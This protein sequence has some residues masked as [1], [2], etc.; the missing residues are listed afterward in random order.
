[1]MHFPQFWRLFT[2][3]SVENR[4]EWK[5]VYLLYQIVTLRETSQKNIG[6]FTL[7]GSRA[8]WIAVVTEKERVWAHERHRHEVAAKPAL[9]PPLKL[10]TAACSARN[11]VRNFPLESTVTA[12]D[13]KLTRLNPCIS[14]QFISIFLYPNFCKCT[15]FFQN[16]WIYIFISLSGR[17]RYYFDK[18]LAF[19]SI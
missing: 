1:M 9:T 4:N 10:W 17:N 11:S 3:R 5:T 14:V 15:I 18:I 12:I 16:I 7:Q 6:S 8:N 19:Y 13:T 2:T